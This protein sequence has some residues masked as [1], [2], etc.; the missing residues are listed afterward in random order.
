[1]R[2]F[3]RLSSQEV[4]FCTKVQSTGHGSL[5]CRH[6]DHFTTYYEILQSSQQPSEVKDKAMEEILDQVSLVHG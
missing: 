6:P 5:A 2:E 4:L 1:M 3:I